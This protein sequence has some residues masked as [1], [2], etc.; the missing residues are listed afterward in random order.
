MSVLCPAC[1]GRQFSD[2]VLAVSYKQKNL[3]D[4]LRMTALQARE[5]FFEQRP[6]AKVLDAVIDM[7]LGYVTLGQN[8]S[9]FSGGEAQR[10]KLLR[11]LKE[12]RGAKPSVLIFDEPTTGLSDR[13]VLNLISQLQRLTNQGHTVIVVEHHLGVLQA[14]DWLVEIGP[15]AAAAGGDLVFQGPPQ[16][17]RGHATSLTAPHLFA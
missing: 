11:L 15:E 1:E 6:I 13:D 3:L 4:I 17:L 16:D 12:A 9:S 2:R 14:S 5:F 7:G 10:L 8:T